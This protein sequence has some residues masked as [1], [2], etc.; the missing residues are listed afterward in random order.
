M[1]RDVQYGERVAGWSLIGLILIV[2]VAVMAA[3]AR[4]QEFAPTD[5]QIEVTIGRMLASDSPVEEWNTDK[6]TIIFATGGLG[7]VAAVKLRSGREGT[8][9]AWF[10][11]SPDR[12]FLLLAKSVDGRTVIVQPTKEGRYSA[13]LVLLIGGQLAQDQTTF[14]VGEQPEP[15]D[16]PD[17][18]DPPN[19]DA[20]WQVM[21]FSERADA[22]GYPKEQR[23]MLSSQSFRDELESRGHIFKGS[24][25]D[26]AQ[27]LDPLMKIWFDEIRG[28]LMPRVAIAPTTGGKVK[29]Y[30]L[31]TT[32]AELWKLLENPE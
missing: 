19:P 6:G 1:R 16:P 26:D 14:D 29:D 24:F 9:Y 21:F 22:L 8:S 2:I 7:T 31:P 32:I 20:K 28:D 30:P 27:I 13:M 3:V 18:P 15:P 17:P 10:V 4:G 12:E 5:S 25:D 23:Q 11:Q